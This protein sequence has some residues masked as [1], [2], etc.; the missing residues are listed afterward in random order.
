MVPMF[1]THYNLI[2][3][4]S[5]AY[6]RDRW[7]GLVKIIRS[8]PE[9]MA[10]E[11]RIHALPKD[12]VDPVPQPTIPG[13]V[14]QDQSPART[15]ALV[16]E[17]RDVLTKVLP[18]SAVMTTASTWADLLAFAMTEGVLN[19]RTMYFYGFGSRADALAP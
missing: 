12:L 17:I 14:S 11:D 4:I 2:D 1:N 6:G 7:N 19:N 10:I 5:Q 13:E 16:R 3:T 18:C 15:D 9:I 8:S